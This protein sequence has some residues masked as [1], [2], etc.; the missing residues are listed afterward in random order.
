MNRNLRKKDYVNVCHK[1]NCVKAT[2]KNAKVIVFSLA[3]M[4]LLF[5]ISSF[6]KSN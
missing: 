4:F 2:G 5:G 6:T 3:T 1:D